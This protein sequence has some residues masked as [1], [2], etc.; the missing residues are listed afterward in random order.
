M[1]VI[2]GIFKARMR[3][4]VRPLRVFDLTW[5]VLLVFKKKENTNSVSRLKMKCL[6]EGYALSNIQGRISPLHSPKINLLYR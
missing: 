4:F 5:G 6:P 1:W 3:L 2:L